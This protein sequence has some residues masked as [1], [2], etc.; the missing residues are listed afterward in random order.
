MYF[1]LKFLVAKAETPKIDKQGVLIRFRGKAYGKK[2]QK[3]KQVGENTCLF[4]RIYPIRI[5][6]VK[7][8]KNLRKALKIL[9]S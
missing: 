6:G 5:S 8:A 1:Q 7:L 9:G 2:N 4:I 3:I